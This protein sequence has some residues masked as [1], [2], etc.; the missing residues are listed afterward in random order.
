MKKILIP[1][2][3]VLALA[4]SAAGQSPTS[5][6]DPV[7][8]RANEAIK[9][10]ATALEASMATAQADLDAVEVAAAAAVAKASAAQVTTSAVEI[11][12]T[13]F[14][15]AFVGQALIATVSNLVWIA[16]G[17]TTNG[18]ILITN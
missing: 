12:T 10:R 7:A 5:F 16:E 2:A 9:A 8:Y 4:L 13:A 3:L 1:A 6:R 17:V 18:W 14:T 11:V 15:P